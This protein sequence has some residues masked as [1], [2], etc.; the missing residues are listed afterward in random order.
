MK[1]R[2]ALLMVLSIAGLFAS[3]AGAGPAFPPGFKTRTVAMADGASL[4]VRS[5]GSGPAV[6]LLH[7]FGDT[8]DMLRNAATDVRKEV[9]PDAG[10]WLMEEST[11]MTVGLISGFLAVSP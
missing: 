3:R 8:G 10:H 2:L 4:F 11:A 1:N 6:V 5:G 9:V 7:G